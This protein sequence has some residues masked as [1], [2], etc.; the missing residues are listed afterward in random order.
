[1]L[2]DGFILWTINRYP[3]RKGYDPIDRDT[4]GGLLAMGYYSIEEDESLAFW[5]PESP[6]DEAIVYERFPI[7]GDEDEWDQDG[8]GTT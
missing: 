6:P 5:S 1:M 4:R 8:S 7:E 2:P 3:L